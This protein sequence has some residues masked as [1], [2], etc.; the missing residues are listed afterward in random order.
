VRFIRADVQ[1]AALEPA[2]FDA[3]LLEC[4]LSI[5]PDKPA[6]LERIADALKPGARLGLT[7]VTV[8]GAIPQEYL[9]AL[10][11]AGCVGDA[12]GLDEYAGLLEG[13]GLRIVEY[14]HL[15]GVASATVLDI[16]GKLMMAEVAVRL[17]KLP[18]GIS[19]IERGKQLI[20]G[21]QRLIADGTP[22]YGL[23]VPEKP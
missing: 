11:V 12:R 9:G 16:K 21:V 4:V 19:L 14:E 23:L 6:S 8:S 15:P 17:G 18:F 3:A 1:T 22:G 20:S 13:A 10:T 5:L 7:D 2:S